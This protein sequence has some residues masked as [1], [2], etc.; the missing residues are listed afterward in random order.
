MDKEDNDS[1]TIADQRPDDITSFVEGTDYKKIK[2]AIF[3]FIIFILVSSDVFIE[4][5][6]SGKDS[7]YVE[8]RYATSKGTMVQGILLVFGYILVSI[9]ISCDYI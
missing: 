9:L 5:V 6:L 4:K 8:G 2:M 1:E 7:T 3:L